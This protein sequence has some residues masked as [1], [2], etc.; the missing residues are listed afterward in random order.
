MQVEPSQDHLQVVGSL[1]NSEV[2]IQSRLAAITKQA[3]AASVRK[4]MDSYH[5]LLRVQ[6]RV[7]HLEAVHYYKLDS[8]DSEVTSFSPVG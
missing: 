8:K 7:E 5:L 2:A 6:P 4:A 1:R 3:V